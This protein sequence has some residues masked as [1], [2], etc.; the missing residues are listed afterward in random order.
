[1]ATSRTG[2]SQW[3]NVRDHALRLA[4]QAGQTTCPYCGIELD[5]NN[6]RQHNGAWVDHIQADANGGTSTIENLQVCCA[7]CNMSKSNRA[8]PKQK[9]ILKRQPLKTSRQW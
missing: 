3:L 9:T 4:Q 7:R 6:R 8:A 2:T 1:M 5:Y